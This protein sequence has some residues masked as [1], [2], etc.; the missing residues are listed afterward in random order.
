MSHGEITIAINISEAPSC[1]ITLCLERQ[2]FQTVQTI[3]TGNRVDRAGFTSAASPA[4]TP[5]PIQWRQLPSS[6][7][8]AIKTPHAKRNAE[9]GGSHTHVIAH[10]KK[11][12]TSAH[13]HPAMSPTVRPKM[14]FPISQIGQQV[15][16][17]K[18]EFTERIAI[19]EAFENTPKSRKIAA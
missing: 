18:I 3:S 6:I 7:R 11:N 5:N 8:R 19:A 13:D 10:R 4:S 2:S 17:A 15:S 9:I 14:R 1:G 12:G 16:A